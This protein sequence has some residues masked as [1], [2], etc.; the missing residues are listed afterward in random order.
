MT[1][2]ELAELINMAVDRGYNA[3]YKDGFDDGLMAARKKFDELIDE[4]F[5]KEEEKEFME[6]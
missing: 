2:K 6:G 4:H 5:R 3:G 1:N